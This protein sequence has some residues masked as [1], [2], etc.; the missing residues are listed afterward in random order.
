MRVRSGPYLRNDAPG[1]VA[2]HHRTLDHKIGDSHVFQVVHVAATYADGTDLY[3]VEQKTANVWRHKNVQRR[4]HDRCQSEPPAKTAAMVKAAA[5][6][7][8]AMTTASTASP[9]ATND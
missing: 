4:K 6:T 1:F 8:T 5:S 9:A 7:A 3:I 2:D